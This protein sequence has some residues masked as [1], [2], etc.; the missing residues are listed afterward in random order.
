M[1]PSPRSKRTPARPALK[2]A[3]TA[4][5]AKHHARTRRAHA[6][7][8]AE[9]YVEAVAELIEESGRARVVDLARRLGVSHV[10]V[11]RTVA[12]LQRDGLVETEPYRSIGLTADGAALAEKVRSRHEA[13]VR[14]L[15]ALGVDAAT[16]RADAEGIEHHVSE[17]TLAAFERFVAGLGAQP[18]K[19]A[20][21]RRA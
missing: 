8:T 20:P 19:K 5:H 10:S 1:A 4:E 21:R 17:A 13:V 9:D 11:V 12:R 18:H 6:R 16:A 2:S 14:F 7:E 3:S 15:V